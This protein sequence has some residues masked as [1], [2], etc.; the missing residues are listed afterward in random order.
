LIASIYGMNF[1]LLPEL[2][3]HYS[4]FFFSIGLMV[5]SMVLTY[6]VFKRKGWL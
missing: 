6:V 1:R 3:G 4:N 5:G 2:P